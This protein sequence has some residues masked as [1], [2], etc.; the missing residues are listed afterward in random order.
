M[1]VHIAYGY[2]LFT[3][4]LGAHY[5][6]VHGSATASREPAASTKRAISLSRRPATLMR[7]A[8]VM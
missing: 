1:K 3:G 6:R 2:G 7:A 8:S 4:G 5:A